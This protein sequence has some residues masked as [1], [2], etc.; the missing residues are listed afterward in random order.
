M[1]Q[2]DGVQFLGEVVGHV[3]RFVVVGGQVE[4]KT[5]GFAH[6]FYGEEVSSGVT[7]P[8]AWRSLILVDVS[9]THLRCS[10]VVV[11]HD[12]V[13]EIG[14]WLRG[15]KYMAAYGAGIVGGAGGI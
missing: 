2:A 1:V 10:F 12:P 5:V 3:N 6:G 14:P 15:E 7:V 9:L 13:L 8:I 4:A 11:T